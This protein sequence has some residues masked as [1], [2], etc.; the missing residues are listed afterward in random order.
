V[1]KEFIQITGK[2]IKSQ[3]QFYQLKYRKIIIQIFESLVRH[4][5][6]QVGLDKIYKDY[7][8]KNLKDRRDEL[9]LISVAYDFDT[10][11][12][13]SLISAGTLKNFLKK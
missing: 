4:Y 6:S 12:L 3:E 10:D 1:I 2:V 7:I 11:M 8:L 9:A 5:D 13:K